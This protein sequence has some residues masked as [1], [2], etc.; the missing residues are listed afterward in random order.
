[1]YEFN[2]ARPTS[3]ADA[4]AN[5]KVAGDDGVF[6]A[7]GQTLIPALKLRLQRPSTVI[8]LGALPGLD[9]IE[10]KGDQL[11]IGALTRHAAVASSK[12]VKDTIAA[13]A[14]L[15]DGIGDPQ[16]LNRQCRSGRGL[17]SRRGRVERRDRHRPTHHCRG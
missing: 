6:L 7:G 11:V 9:T 3:L 5:M 13:L 4:A 17:S 2:Y 16:V 15:A 12:V 1:M 10:R 8:D 14:S